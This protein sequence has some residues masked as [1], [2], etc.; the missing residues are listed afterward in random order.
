MKEKLKSILKIWKKTILSEIILY[1]ILTTFDKNIVGFKLPQNLLENNTTCKKF[2]HL[3]VFNNQLCNN[4]TSAKQF[5][6]N[7]PV[8]IFTKAGKAAIIV[9]R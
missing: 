6:N 4:L 9:V 2:K 1:N 7:N 3:K 5:I 8:L